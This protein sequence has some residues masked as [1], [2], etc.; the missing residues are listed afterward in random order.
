MK[1]VGVLRVFHRTKK[2]SKGEERVEKVDDLVDDLREKH[3][4][5]CTNLQ[6]RVWAETMVGGQHKS[7]DYP[8]KG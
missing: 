1:A 2:K 7:L 3:G 5:S 4:I 8:P 6:Y